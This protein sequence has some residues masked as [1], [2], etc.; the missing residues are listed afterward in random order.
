MFMSRD[1]LIRN[2]TTEL[3]TTTEHRPGWNIVPLL[4]VNISC[5]GSLPL[6]CYGRDLVSCIVTPIPETCY[7]HYREG[8]TVEPLDVRGLESNPRSDWRE[9]RD[10]V[11]TLLWNAHLGYFPFGFMQ[12]P[13]FIVWVK[14]RIHLTSVPFFASIKWFSLSHSPIACTRTKQFTIVPLQ[15]L[16]QALAWL[17]SR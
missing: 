2:F 10:R 3:D 16:I 11:F 7:S 5:S 8:W 1:H 6:M 12:N 13:F 15:Q 4:E 9:L 14:L 17:F